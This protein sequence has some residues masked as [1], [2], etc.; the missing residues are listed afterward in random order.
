MKKTELLEILEHPKG[1]IICVDMDMTLC[2]GIWWGH[3]DP[4]PEPIKEMVD[5]VDKLAHKEACIIIYSARQ[6]ELYPE[7]LAWLIKHRVHFTG[8]CL[9][10]KPAASVYID[11]R[12]LNPEDL[13]DIVSTQ[14]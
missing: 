12:A 7:T 11:D 14:E 2:N 3:D 4:D 10:V 6:P 8:I 5:F 13:V 9:G 1:R